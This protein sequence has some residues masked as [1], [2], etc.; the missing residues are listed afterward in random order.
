MVAL[1][2]TYWLHRYSA[3]DPRRGG[4]PAACAPVKWRSR[5]RPRCAAASARQKDFD[6]AGLSAVARVQPDL[7]EWDHGGY[8]GLPTSEIVKKRPGF[9]ILDF[10]PRIAAAATAIAR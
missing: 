7:A 6:L 9:G 8:E 5:L 4:G 2:T 3:N 1:R 10:M